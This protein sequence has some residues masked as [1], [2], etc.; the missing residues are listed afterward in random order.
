M[1]MFQ[2]IIIIT[3]LRSLSARLYPFYVNSKTYHNNKALVF[4]KTTKYVTIVTSPSSNTP[5]SFSNDFTVSRDDRLMSRD[6][7]T[8]HVTDSYIP[9]AHSQYIYFA[10]WVLQQ[11]GTF[12]AIYEMPSKSYYILNVFISVFFSFNRRFIRYGV[13]L[14]SYT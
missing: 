2:G 12:V 5:D 11:I 7:V 9:Q 4:F 1:C 10:A 3:C 14:V 13:V 8:F 6:T